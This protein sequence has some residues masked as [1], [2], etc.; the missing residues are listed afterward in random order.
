MPAAGLLAMRAFM[1][2]ALINAEM[3]IGLG[4]LAMT[5]LGMSSA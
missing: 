4:I 1:P 3:L 2:V 5:A